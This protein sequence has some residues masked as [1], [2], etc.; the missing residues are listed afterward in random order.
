MGGGKLQQQKGRQYEAVVIGVSA[1]GLAAL[2]EVL[3]ALA[4]DFPMPVLI[5]QH[6]SRLSEGILSR[7]LDEVSQVRVKEAEDKESAVPGVVYIAPANYHLLV[8]EDGSLALSLEERV[9]F[10]RP[11]VDVLF[12]AAADVYGPRLIGVVL[13]GANDDGSRGLKKIKERGGLTIVQD[14]ATA[15]ADAMPRAAIAASRVDYIL[16]LTEIGPLLNSLA[17]G[18]RT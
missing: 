6:M 8:E 4:P 12:E 1:G 10:A 9:N 15:V 11:A 7:L 5:V 14:P 13:T 16:P 17:D 18:R 3:P 2:R